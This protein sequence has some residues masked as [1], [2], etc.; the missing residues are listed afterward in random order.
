[1][2]LFV[3]LIRFQT[4]L[5]PAPDGGKLTLV[6]FA[7]EFLQYFSDIFGPGGAVYHYG[8]VEEDVVQKCLHAR[9]RMEARWVGLIFAQDEC[10]VQVE[11]DEERLRRGEHGVW[12]VSLLEVD[13]GGSR[14]R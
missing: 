5:V 1:M 4:E 8:V 11:Y 10:A 9:P 12:P 13:Q 7:K 2:D 14:N 3:V 6:F